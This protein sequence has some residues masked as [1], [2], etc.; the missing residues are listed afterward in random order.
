MTT[1]EEY[2]FTCYLAAKKS[3]D[4]RALNPA[5]RQE[6]ARALKDLPGQT[7]V[8]VLEVGAGIGTMLE[9]LLDWGLLSHAIYTG[10]DF[11]PEN[12]VEAR[13]RL[14][15]DA[16]SRGFEQSGGPNGRLVWERQQQRLEVSF[17]VIDLFDFLAREQG[18]NTWHLLIAHA[19]LDLVDLPTA[20]PSLFSLLK[21][22]ALFYFTLNFDGA[23]I[24]RPPLDEG[25]DRLVE[26]LYHQTMDRRRVNGKPAGSSRT[27]RLL[28]AHLE[29]D[30]GLQLLAAG[31]S[32][33]VVAPT[34]AGYP[35]DEAYFLHFIV[36]TIHQA[37]K[38]HPEMDGARLAQWTRARHRQ[39]EGGELTY[40]ARQWD[41]LG[42]LR[43]G[44]GERS[45]PALP[46]NSPP[47]PL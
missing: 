42:K 43:G 17:E 19:F 23:T 2:R 35:A 34:R 32:D 1:P 45:S 10:I 20:L 11:E 22:K 14:A 16:A 5:V 15:R 18:R 26:K 38:D 3:V 21:A 30:P 6:L 24:L 27:G 12:L 25:F 46:S 47:N 4:D 8:Q 13:Q 33:W 37:L 28:K 40:I 31:R 41:F 29:S 39:I 9:R 44:P 36:Q 7:P